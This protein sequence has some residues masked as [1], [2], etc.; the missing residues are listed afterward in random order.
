MLAVAVVA[1][2]LCRAAA[3]RREGVYF[4]HVVSKGT[5]IVSNSGQKRTVHSEMDILCDSQAE[6]SLVEA[7]L[8]KSL[9]DAAN[10]AIKVLTPSAGKR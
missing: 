9:E 4:M 10:R 2:G 3:P 6:A 5:R 7:T 1:S 8:K